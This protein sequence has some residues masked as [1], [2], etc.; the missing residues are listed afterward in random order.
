MERPNLLHWRYKYLREIRK[1]RQEKRNIVYLDETWVDNDLT[2]KKCWQ[3]YT[4]SGV[5]SNIGS[6]GRLI[7]VHAGS[8]NGFVDN[9]CLIFKAGLATGDYHG[10]M[11]KEN[12]TR[13]LTEKLLPNIPPNSVIVYD[14]A[15]Y[16]SV[17]EDSN[18]DIFEKR[19][20]SLVNEKRN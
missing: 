11:N 10:Q 2:F 5:I 1:Y 15:P 20:S 3:S 18:Q 17:Q 19:H 14:N 12:F 8:V 16:H 9:A 6:T 7:I 4:V 13:W